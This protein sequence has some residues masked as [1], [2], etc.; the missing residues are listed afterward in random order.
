MPVGLSPVWSMTDTQCT[1][2][3]HFEALKLALHQT[4]A[5]QARAG[6]IHTCAFGRYKYNLTN[7]QQCVKIIVFDAIHGARHETPI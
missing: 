6:R 5:R 7:L 3:G 1:K 2:V 4:H